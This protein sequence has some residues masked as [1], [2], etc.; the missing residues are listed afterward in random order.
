MPL[1]RVILAKPRGFCAG[2]DRAIEVVEQA[3]ERFPGPVYVRKEIV[4]N[5]HVVNA[6]R[7]KGAVFVDELTEVPAGATTIFSAHGV[8]PAVHE[9]AR[10]RQLQVI[11][12]TCPLVTK[13]HVEAKRFAREGS[14]MLLIG[15]AGHE[16][17]EGTM[18][19]APASIRLIQTVEDAKTVSVPDPDRV[20]VITQTTLSMDDT[21]AIIDAL[22]ARFPKLVVPAKEDICY[23]TQ[24]RQNAVKALAKDA[25]VILVI[26]ANNSSNSIR[27]TEVAEA[28]GRRAHLINDA[29]E[30][31]AGWFE[32]VGCV[33]V[34]SG[35]SAPEH[36]VQEVVEALKR[37]GATQVEEWELTREDVSFGLPLELQRL[38][39]GSE[40]PDPASSL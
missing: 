22:K 8:S 2:V 37:L 25:E 19:E 9:A 10:Q 17:V 32:G 35:A 27:L 11:D 3:L 1:Q 34:T 39:A 38:E 4:H 36:L 7:R 40:K 13:V 26:G 23:A 30:I 33:G 12:A 21:R 31:Q 14:T 24:N 15:H 28:A 29:G 6:L 16:E 20:A 5:P 18:G